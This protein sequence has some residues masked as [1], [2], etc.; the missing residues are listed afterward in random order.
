MEVV[1]VLSHSHSQVFSRLFHVPLMALAVIGAL[2]VA[3]APAQADAPQQ[4]CGAYVAQ[5]GDTATTIAAQF[6]LNAQEIVQI[7]HLSGVNAAL[8]AGRSLTLCYT[9]LAPKVSDTPNIP[10]QPASAADTYWAGEP[11]HSTDYVDGPIY[12]WKVPPSCYAG[13]YYINPKNYVSRA[14][15]G[16]CNWW[17]EVLHPDRPNI[18][19]EARHSTPIPGAVVVF[20]GG[21]QGASSDGHYGEVV[22]ILG[23]G[24]ILMSEMNDTW[25][26][27]GFARVN[28]RYVYEDA[29]VTYIY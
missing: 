3:I 29:N 8:Q 19:H 17:P 4:V 5:A 11:C 28:Y 9:P 2:V 6:M 21:E 13:V 25:R 22:A 23:N 15:F 14:G 16:W 1:I 27:A 7:N 24:W 10:A 12:M 20:A 18:L 26:G